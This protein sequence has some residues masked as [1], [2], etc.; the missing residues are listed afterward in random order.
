MTRSIL[1][2]LLITLSL[3]FF[4]D[5]AYPQST[6][7]KRDTTGVSFDRYFIPKTLR[8]DFVLAGDHS[9]ETAYLV[10]LKQ[11]PYWGGTKKKLVDPY[12]MGSYRCQVF[13][14]ASGTLI[15]SRGFSTL[16]QEWRGTQ[17]ANSVKRAFSQTAIMPFP[18]RNV[19]IEVEK[20]NF[21]T[22]L[23]TPLLTIHIDPADYMISKE[24]PRPYPFIKFRDSGDPAQKVDIAFIAEGYTEEEMSK[25]LKDAQRITDYFLTVSPYS[26][27]KTKFN[28]YAILT[29]S[30]ESGVDIPG[31]SIY[32]NTPVN[33]TFYTFGMD[34]YLTTSDARSIYDIAACVPYDAIFVLVNSKLYGGGGFY[35]HYAEIT[36]DNLWSK[37]V[38]VHEFGHS[39]A[40]LADEYMGD[41][42]YTDTY[43]LAVEPWEPNITTNIDFK[44]KWKNM[45]PEGT[46]I[47]T[48]RTEEFKTS[49]GMFEGGGYVT[50]GIYSPYQDCRMKS[51]EAPGFCPVCNNAIR[52]M[53][54]FYC[55]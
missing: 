44:S 10:Q 31:N 12:N 1:L 6:L 25:F 38:A 53:I 18:Q 54:L 37:V 4:E 40:G 55:E 41:I 30:V 13:D 19:R 47:P 11:E 42:S 16:F 28:F 9:S 14:S 24:K 17:E 52:R 26:E 29:P 36:V 15:F 22:G 23:F 32:V 21:S 33:S 45:I 3:L 50:K 2:F 43:N 8:L 51:N 46:P 5:P 7:Q 20:R 34:R 49:V 27:F 48:P 35:N 39:F